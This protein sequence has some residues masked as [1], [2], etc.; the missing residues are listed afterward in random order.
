MA[1]YKIIVETT[2]ADLE[3]STAPLDQEAVVRR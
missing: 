1:E 2:Q 3:K